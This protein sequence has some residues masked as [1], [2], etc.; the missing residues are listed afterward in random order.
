MLR[1]SGLYGYGA[2]DFQGNIGNQIGAVNNAWNNEANRFNLGRSNS[3]QFPSATETLIAVNP[4]NRNTE[5]LATAYFVWNPSDKFSLGVWANWEYNDNGTQAIGFDN[6]G[7]IKIASGSRNIVSAGIRP[8]FWVS[9]N[10]AIQGAASGSYID[11]VRS[12][13]GAA[14]GRSGEYGIV[15]IAPT[16]KPKGGFFTRPEIRL[17]ATFAAWSNSLKGTSA[18]GGAVGTG[19]TNNGSIPYSNSNANY[20][21]LFGSQ[22]EIWF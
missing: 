2:T 10:I 13:T 1:L 7:K 19:N 18:A 20:G 15:T 21:W 17:F 14:F 9:D 11:N 6:H 5:A 22:M 3:V 16:I 8:V 12:Q 4:V